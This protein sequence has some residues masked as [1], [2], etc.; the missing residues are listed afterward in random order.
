MKTKEELNILKAEAAA[1]NKKLAELPDDEL[2]Q[3]AGGDKIPLSTK[4]PEVAAKGPHASNDY[5]AGKNPLF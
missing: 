3:V 5:S 1:L 4:Q 2:A